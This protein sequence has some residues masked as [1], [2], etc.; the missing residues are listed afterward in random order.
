M[1]STVVKLDVTHSSLQMR[2]AEIRFTV[3]QTVA[4]VKVRMN[5]YHNHKLENP[6]S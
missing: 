2:L 4:S 1:Q 5:L 3:D 6:I